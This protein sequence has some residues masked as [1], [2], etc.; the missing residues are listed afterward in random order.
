MSFWWQLTLD[1]GPTIAIAIAIALSEPHWITESMLK[2]DAVDNVGDVANDANDINDFVVVSYLKLG[3]ML[4]Y[5]SCFLIFSKH[6]ITG[7]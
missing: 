4:L 2:T 6:L 3:L 1:P 5:L 7:P